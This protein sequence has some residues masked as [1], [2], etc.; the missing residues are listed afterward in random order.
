MMHH[1]LAGRRHSLVIRRFGSPGAFLTEPGALSG[2]ET[3]TVL[4]PGLEVPEGAEVGTEVDVFVYFDSEDR[5]IATTR[6]PK[7]ELAQVAFLEVTALSKFG[8]FVDWGLP[9]EL[10]VPFSEQT[11]E[12]HLGAR[13]PIGLYIDSSGRLAGT[14]RVSEMLGKPS[15]KLALDEWLDGEAWRSDPDFG[16]FVILERSFTGLVPAQEPHQLKRG[17]AVRAR[18]VEL[19]P[20]GKVVLSLRGHA[21][22]ELDR[23]AARILEVLRGPSP[24]RLGDR[25]DPEEIRATFGLTKKAFK[26]AVGR[27]LRLRCVRIDADGCVSAVDE[28]QPRAAT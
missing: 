7:L 4:L 26:R 3:P 10:L 20:D 23:D 27:L 9:K 8:A 1:G 17:E 11:T 12:L 13:H 16:L 5:P 25:S 15:R 2:A 6:A 21:F 22:E 24:P 14:M 28:T 18:V 19:L